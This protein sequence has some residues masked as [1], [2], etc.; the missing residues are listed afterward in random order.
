MCHIAYAKRKDA[1]QTAH[2]RSLISVF[3]FRGKYLWILS[4][5]YRESEGVI[6]R[7][8]WIAYSEFSLPTYCCKVFFVCFTRLISLT[9]VQFTCFCAT[10]EIIPDIGTPF[11]I[12]HY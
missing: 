6:R 5:L 9:C 4:D 3:R 1:D 11:I 10:T 8:R 2:P 12:T 7:Y